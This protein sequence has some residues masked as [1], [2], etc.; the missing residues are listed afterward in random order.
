[1][2]ELIDFDDVFFKVEEIYSAGMPGYICRDC[3]KQFLI[4]QTNKKTKDLE[5]L[6]NDQYEITNFGC[7]AHINYDLI[8]DPVFGE[9]IKIPSHIGNYKELILSKPEFAFTILL[10]RLN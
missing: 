5:I 8:V 4:I 2:D 1:M 6:Y 3:G 10:S 7:N 9:T